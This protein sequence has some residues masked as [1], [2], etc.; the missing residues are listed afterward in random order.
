[1]DKKFT[2]SFSDDDKIKSAL[3][4]KKQRLFYCFYGLLHRIIK[5]CKKLSH[6]KKNNK[7]QIG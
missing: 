2:L 5:R 6:Y 1:M 4:K 3:F 7:F